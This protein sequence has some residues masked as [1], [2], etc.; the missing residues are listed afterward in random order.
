[1]KKLLSVILCIALLISVLAINYISSSAFV[2]QKYVF[3]AEKCFDSN[4]TISKTSTNSEYSGWNSDCT[5]LETK[6][7]FLIHDNNNAAAV[8][9][10][11]TFNLSGLEIGSY[12]VYFGYRTNGNRCTYRVEAFDSTNAIQ[13]LDSAISFMA[14]SGANVKSCG[15]SYFYSVKTTNEVSVS[16]GSTLTLKLTIESLPAA[17][18]H[19][20]YID[21]ILLVN[22]SS[23]GEL[24]SNTGSTG[25][26]TPTTQPTTQPTTTKPALQSGTIYVDANNATNVANS[27][28]KTIAEAVSA[29]AAGSNAS[30]GTTIKLLSDVTVDANITISKAYLTIDLNGFTI[31]GRGGSNPQNVQTFTVNANN[32]TVQNGKMQFNTTGYGN[33][34]YLINNA[35]ADNVLT[36]KNVDFSYEKFGD[37]NGDNTPAGL[38]RATAVNTTNIYDC[39]FKYN[40]PARFGTYAYLPLISCF[41]TTMN[42]YNCEL[43]G[44]ESISAFAI[45]SLNSLNTTN[46]NL[47][48]VNIKNCKYL[49]SKS[50]T[51]GSSLKSNIK[52]YSGSVK[53]VDTLYLEPEMTNF[54]TAGK[55]IFTKEKNG[56]TSINPSDLSSPYVFYATCS[57]EFENDACKYCFAKIEDEKAVDLELVNG[58]SIRL[59]MPTGIRFYVNIDIDKIN[60]LKSKGAEIE[61]G[62]LI[63]PLDKVNEL[64]SFTIENVGETCL[65]VPYSVSDLGSVNENGFV[66]SICNINIENTEYSSEYGNTTRPY[67]ARGYAKVTLNGETYIS[68]S[69][70]SSELSRSLGQISKRL[71]NDTDAYNALIEQDINM[72]MNVRDWASIYD[73][74]NVSTTMR[75]DFF[76]LPTTGYN[77]VATTEEAMILLPSNYDEK[78]TPTRLII[79]CHGFT[80]SAAKLKTTYTQYQYWAHNGYAILEVDGG[81]S[82]SGYCSMGNPGAVN[83]NVSAYEYVL[84]NYNIKADG[85]FVVGGSMGGIVSENLVCSGRLPVIAHLNI[86]PAMSLYRQVYSYG[87]DPS[88]IK[89]VSLFYN[90]SFDK[91]N[92]D[93]GTSYNQNTF[94]WTNEKQSISAAERELFINNFVDKVVPNCGIW[95]YISCFDYE[96]KTFKP[97]YE[98]FLTATDE[99]RIAEMYNSITIDYPVPLSIYHGTGDRTVPFKYSQYMYNAIQKSETSVCKITPYDTISHGNFGEKH[100]YLCDDGATYNVLSSYD[101]MLQYIREQEQ[102]YTAK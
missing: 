67:I 31:I 36:I 13:P 29:A 3:E 49:F 83:G 97:G 85:V 43:D 58:A 22:T 17:Q 39:T 53:Y 66:A 88:N 65:N 14:Q 94:P 75:Y 54:T 16:T 60:S 37:A 89:R 10:Y 2:G 40:A 63:A 87:W 11:V 81:G 69:D 35:V 45:Q 4:N 86:C 80:G 41:K 95:K 9:D 51:K 1:M 91:Y 7:T 77:G 59:K 28:Y 27:T 79:D 57:H 92:S 6:Q 18:S 99:T 47:Y 71:Q 46:L 82:A 96:T 76:T 84:E 68:Y 20:S 48:N 102:A 26:G 101:E 50:S 90:F 52:M 23:T 73:A 64:G 12:E 44:G 93:H 55:A 32:C 25:S 56:T 72:W 42:L 19:G 33:A 21:K 61:L 24:P 34:S 8:G 15:G 78:G 62:T 98:D 74:A 100:D 5:A 38:V 30:N 70:Y